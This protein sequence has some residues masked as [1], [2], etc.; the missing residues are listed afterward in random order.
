MPA[1]E[2]VLIAVDP[3]IF[4]ITHD[5]LQVLLRQREKE[6][7][8]GKYELPGGLVQHGE[9]AELALSRKL[10]EILGTQNVFF[11]QFHTFTAPQRDPRARTASIGFIALVS[12]DKIPAGEEW[13]SVDQLPLLAF[14]HKDIITKARAYLRQ[15]LDAELLRQFLPEKFPLNNLQLVHEIIMQEKYDNRNFRKKMVAAGIVEETGE[16]EQN[17]SHRPAKLYRFKS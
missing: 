15:H 8:K 11:T 14:D 5:H 13:L 3:V 4:T 9:T 1:Y 6:P 2:R 10:T 17:V 7:F 16:S 12:R